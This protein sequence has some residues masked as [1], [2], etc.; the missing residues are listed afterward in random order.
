M[1]LYTST[2]DASGSKVCNSWRGAGFESTS[3]VPRACISHHPAV[4]SKAAACQLS[5]SPSCV[6]SGTPYVY[7]PAPI[8]QN[9][10]WHWSWG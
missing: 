2:S 1:Q 4:I 3:D 10:F 6:S 8:W 9:G 5:R 7:H